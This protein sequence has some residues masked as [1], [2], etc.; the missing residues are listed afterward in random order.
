MT[1]TILIV[2][3]VDLCAATLE[4]A[5]LTLPDLIVQSA[6]SAE[7]AWQFLLGGGISALITDIHLP[8]MD[9]FELIQRIR[10]QP[11][12]TRLPI[13]VI[14]GDSDPATPGRLQS[15]GAD[16][17]FSKPYSPAEVRARLEQLIHV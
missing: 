12:F 8:K 10:S 1:R 2:E 13:L 3:D 4:I 7:E 5:L 16:A 15:L 14:S 9:G 6:T 11:R 17:Y